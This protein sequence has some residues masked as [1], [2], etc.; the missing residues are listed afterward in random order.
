M[1]EKQLKDL[2]IDIDP[3]PSPKKRQYLTEH[4]EFIIGIG[5]D[6][7]ATITMDVEAFEKLK[8]LTLDYTE[9][10]THHS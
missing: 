2:I 7:C 8:E 5:K 4:I 9:I 6:D 3:I 10:D 1:K